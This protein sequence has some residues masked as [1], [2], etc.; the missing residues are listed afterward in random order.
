MGAGLVTGV[1]LAVILAVG[2]LWMLVGGL[3]PTQGMWE[4]YGYL[5]VLLALVGAGWL[6]IRKRVDRL[7]N[8]PDLLG[9]SILVWATLALVTSILAPGTSYL[10]SWP[11]VLGAAFWVALPTER[12]ERAGGLLFLS[13]V[14]AALIVNVPA[15]DIFFQMAQPRPGNPDSLLL[16]VAGIAV[17]LGLLVF[18]LVQSIGRDQARTE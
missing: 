11:A 7:P 5:L 17:G 2:M 16:P 12:S 8:G 9:G 18:S 14:G 15:V 1:F 13:V 3:R 6:A 10:F 4:A